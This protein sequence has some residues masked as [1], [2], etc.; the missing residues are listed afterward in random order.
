MR[1]YGK[2]MT[3][4]NITRLGMHGDGIAEGP[5]FAPMTLPD[6]V[7]TGT[8]EGSTLRDIKIVTPSDD[9][10]AAPAPA[11]LTQESPLVV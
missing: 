5:V 8:L 10:V 9:R 7:V 3:E 1:R 2:G 4:F 6:E 11:V